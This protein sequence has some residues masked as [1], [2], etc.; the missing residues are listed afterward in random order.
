MTDDKIKKLSHR[1]FEEY[2][3]KNE[4]SLCLH[5]GGKPAI[6]QWRDTKNPNASWI[7]CAHCGMNTASFY[8]KDILKAARKAIEAWNRS[9][10]LYW[11]GR[12]KK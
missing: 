9:A 6:T 7:T 8:D 4:I 12:P 11:K 5:C 3:V 1:K 10:C 2:L